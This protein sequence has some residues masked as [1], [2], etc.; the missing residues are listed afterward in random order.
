MSGV[1]KDVETEPSA[2]RSEMRGLSQAIEIL[3]V[4]FKSLAEHVLQKAQVLKKNV[5][6]LGETL[7]VT[8]VT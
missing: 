5:A 6:S 2:V 7:Q 8:R 3:P 1:V 4:G